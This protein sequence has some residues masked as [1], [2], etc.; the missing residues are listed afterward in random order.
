M[1][2]AVP[3]WLHGQLPHP[4]PSTPNL[5]A[6]N[7][8]S[9]P[10]QVA[11]LQSKLHSTQEELSTLQSNHASLNSA[12]SEREARLAQQ[13]N[14]LQ[15]YQHA[16]AEQQADIQSAL[17]IMA[18]R[19]TS[20]AA[21]R[22]SQTAGY[23]NHM[24]WLQHDQAYQRKSHS[25]DG[26][27]EPRD[28]YSRAPLSE[29]HSGGIP[30]HTTSADQQHQAA[31]VPVHHSGH[32]ISSFLAMPAQTAVHTISSPWRYQQQGHTA[33]TASCG[34]MTHIPS[35]PASRHTK[36]C[37]NHSPINH[38]FGTSNTNAQW[39]RGSIGQTNAGDTDNQEHLLSR[40]HPVSHSI[41]MQMPRLQHHFIRNKPHSRE[42]RQDYYPKGYDGT[43]P[44][45]QLYGGHIQQ[46][47]DDD[48][49]AVEASLRAATLR[50]G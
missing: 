47:L 12:L 11:S 25:A 28:T 48:I 40:R 42:D 22:R 50:M 31:S 32:M 30:S 38:D 9:V 3:S 19:D 17:S 20:K 35:S 45:E 37:P 15:Q 4:K 24:P 18:Y 21:H 41:E 6:C 23:A 5:Y 2:Q 13:S 36:L 16:A 49:A 26:L 34:H 7:K 8:L 33:G 10:M 1:H 43:T 14:Q 29:P 44:P 27:C 39:N 46:A